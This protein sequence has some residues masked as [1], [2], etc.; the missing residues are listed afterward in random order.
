MTKDEL[1]ESLLV[2]RHLP[3][4]PMPQDPSPMY[5]D[6]EDLVNARRAALVKAVELSEKK[7]RRHSKRI[8]ATGQFAAANARVQEAEDVPRF[9]RRGAILVAVKEDAA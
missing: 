2:E 7:A 3:L 8:R 1:L 5:D 4:P 9:V 6:S